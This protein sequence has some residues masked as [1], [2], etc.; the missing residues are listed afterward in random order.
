DGPQRAPPRRPAPRRLHRGPPALRHLTSPPPH[1]SRL[2]A[3]TRSARST[4]EAGVAGFSV[5]S[6]VSVARFDA[7]RSLNERREN[8]ATA[9][10]DL[11]SFV[12]RA[13]VSASELRVE[14]CNP[15]DQPLRT[16]HPQ[17]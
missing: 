10:A 9:S 15:A 3:S 1:R 7:L 4:N 17:P 5:R 13:G 16:P 11:S 6:R 12:E 14:A 2:H 8:P